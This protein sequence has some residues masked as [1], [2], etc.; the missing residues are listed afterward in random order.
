MTALTHEF[1]ET[2]PASPERVFTALT[3]EAELTRWFA[4]HAEVE[5]RA[6]GE[7]RFWGRNTWCTPMRWEAKQKFVRVQAPGLVVFSWPVAGCESE[8]TLELS[9]DPAEGAGDRTVL[10]GRHFFPEA[11]AVERAEDLVDDIW[12]IT[13]GNLREHLI[14]GA[15]VCLPDFADP[16]P[17]IRQTV[18]IDAPRHKVFHALIDPAALNKWIATNAVVEPHEEGRYSYGWSYDV[19]GR[20]VE[21]GPTKILEVVE[22]VK[23]VTDWPDWRGNASRP[24]Q[25]VSWVLEAIGDQTRVTLIHEPFERTADLSDY[26][27]GWGQFLA[28]LKKQVETPAA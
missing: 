9:K 5:P 12:R 26:P 11:P 21:G 16:V 4:E 6:G 20:K 18:H 14:G 1:T 7:F 10:K 17:R 25:R 2:L 13:V 28:Q 23:L 8:V 15:G 19:K 24:A 22:N 3:D 27:Q